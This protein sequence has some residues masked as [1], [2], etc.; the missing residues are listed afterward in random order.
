MD[1]SNYNPNRY[2]TWS[3]RLV[4]NCVRSGMIVAIVQCG[5]GYMVRVGPR[6]S[7]IIEPDES[8]V[9][10]DEEEEEELCQEKRRKRKIDAP[11][12]M[13]EKKKRSEGQDDDDD[14]APKGQ[15]ICV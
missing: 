9:V 11:T 10:R 2:I 5:Q 13:P 12:G 14:D 4:V 6:G 15:G 8:I 3:K 7:F 1:R